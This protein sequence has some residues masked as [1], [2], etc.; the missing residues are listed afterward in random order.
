MTDLMTLLL[1]DTIITIAK[2]LLH[3]KVSIGIINK[4]TGLDIETIE[5]LK[6]QLEQEQ[7]QEQESEDGE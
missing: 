2:Q 3:E 6:E 1:E 4:S 7:E 5:A